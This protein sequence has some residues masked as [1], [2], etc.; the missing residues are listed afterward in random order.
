MVSEIFVGLLAVPG[1]VHA[2]NFQLSR[3]SLVTFAMASRRGR[4]LWTT[5]SGMVVVEVVCQGKLSNNVDERNNI[6]VLFPER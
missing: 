1:V 5:C 4:W 3:P 2:V 6:I